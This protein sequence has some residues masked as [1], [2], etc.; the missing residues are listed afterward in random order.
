MILVVGI[1]VA[2]WYF[3]IREGDDVTPTPSP[4]TPTATTTVSPTPTE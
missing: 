1:G 4:T 3:I 2:I